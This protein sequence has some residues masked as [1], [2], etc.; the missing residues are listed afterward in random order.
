MVFESSMKLGEEE[1][2]DEIDAEHLIQEDS[3]ENKERSATAIDDMNNNKATVELDMQVNVNQT[4]ELDRINNGKQVE[5]ED[6]SEPEEIE[7]SVTL[8]L[9]NKAKASLRADIMGRSSYLK[10]DLSVTIPLDISENMKV[11]IEDYGSEKPLPHYGLNRPNADYFTS[12]LHMRNMNIIVHKCQLYNSV[13]LNILIGLLLNMFIVK[14][15]QIS[16]FFN[17]NSFLGV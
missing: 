11:T 17:S 12:S 9:S 2:T 6:D 4:D 7:M 3:D 13:K 10:D 14:S 5:V 16:C 1:I 8:K 15:K